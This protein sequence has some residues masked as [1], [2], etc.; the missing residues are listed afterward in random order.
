MFWHLTPANSC[1]E[2]ILFY[3]AKVPNKET[4]AERSCFVTPF[5]LHTTLRKCEVR[6]K[7]GYMTTSN[8]R[9]KFKSWHQTYKQLSTRRPTPETGLR[10]NSPKCEIVCLNFDILNGYPIFEEFKRVKIKED[11]TLLGAL[12]QKGKAVE[13]AL[14]MK[15]TELKRLSDG[16][17]YYPHTTHS[18]SYVTL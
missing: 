15:I 1:S 6:T 7:L 18:V 4:T 10:L 16:Y 8:L 9:N 11:L 14:N 13:K 2:N 3:H 5:I 17:L 12:D